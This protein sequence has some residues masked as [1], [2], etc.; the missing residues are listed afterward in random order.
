MERENYKEAM[1]LLSK[2]IENSPDNH[3]AEEM[4]RAATLHH[5]RAQAGAHLRR[6][7]YARI[8]GEHEQ[9][10]WHF[11]QALGIDKDNLDA[12]HLLA[13]L[14]VEKQQNL[15]RALALMKEV[16]VLGGQRSRYFATLG[17]IFLLAKELDRAA[18]AFNKALTME[19][20]NSDLKKRLRQCK[21]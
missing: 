14:F 3:E 18:D 6:G 10:I 13:E 4:L 21:K 7:R 11:E 2:V 17:E 15:G 1:D 20:N 12:R 19:P 5:Q 9:A 8:E 16:I